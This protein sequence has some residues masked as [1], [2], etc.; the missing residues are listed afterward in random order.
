[1]INE[2]RSVWLNSVPVH[3]KTSGET[4][5]QMG[6]GRE[7]PSSGQGRLREPAAE[8]APHGKVSETL[9]L[10]GK[11]CAFVITSLKPGGLARG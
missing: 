1:M 4:S 9:P 2:Y 10:G 8:R 11:S 3:G 7:L 5:R 6:A